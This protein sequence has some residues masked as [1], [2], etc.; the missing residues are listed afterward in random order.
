MASLTQRKKTGEWIIRFSDGHGDEL[1]VFVGKKPRRLAEEVRR[2]V[3]RLA[4]AKRANVSVA[5]ETVAWLGGIDAGLR[6]KLE[7]VGLVAPAAPMLQIELGEFLDR[8]I[9]QKK[10]DVSDTTIRNLRQTKEKLIAFFKARRNVRSITVEEM[11]QFRAWLVGVAKLSRNTVST[12]L[13]KTKQ[14]FA[15][16]VESGLLATN[17]CRKLRYL[18]D[19]RNEDRERF[20]TPDEAIRV[21]ATCPT[22]EWR[23]IFCLARFGGMRPSEILCLRWEHVVWEENRIRVPGSKGR[24][25]RKRMRDLPIFAEIADALKE[26]QAERPKQDGQVVLSYSSGDN[27]GTQL[28]R[29]IEEAGIEDW[30][31]PFQNLRSTRATELARKGVAIQDFCRWLGHSPK[32]ALEHYLQVQT[33]DFDRAAAEIRTLPTTSLSP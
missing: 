3:E 32:V 14:F 11:N 16:A 15:D 7:R 13:R 21:L 4:E 26:L 9:D 2:H 22:A 24:Q 10:V 25:G 20:M 1:P 18:Q 33:R 5:P 6:G 23:V 28:S 17:P 19:T 27:V 30:E 12:H 31:R 8:Y 29:I